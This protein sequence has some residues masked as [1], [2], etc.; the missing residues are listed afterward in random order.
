[1]TCVGASASGMS[2][3][4]DLLRDAALRGGVFILS[5]PLD[6]LDYLCYIMDV[7]YTDAKVVGGVFAMNQKL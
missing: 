4:A 7:N 5:F 2:F 6:N 1:M 3:D